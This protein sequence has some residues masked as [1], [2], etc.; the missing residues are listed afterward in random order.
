[1]ANFCINGTFLSEKRTG[2]YRFAEEIIKALDCQINE[3]NLILVVP[4]KTI[5]PFH[6]KKIKVVEFGIKKGILWEQTFFALYLFLH[7]A[8]AI[9][10]CNVTPLIAPRG[11]SVIHD[12]NY[13]VNPQ[14]FSHFYGKLS[15]K[16]HCIQYWIISHFAQHIFTVSEFSKSE[17]MRVYG[18]DE[19]KITVTPNGWQHMLSIKPSLQE[20]I[21]KFGLRSQCYYL[22]LSTIAPNK[23][24]K[25]VLNAAKNNPNEIFA[26][27]GSLNPAR[28]G[29]ELDI[30]GIQNVKFLG[31]ISDEDF[32]T[33]AKNCKAF[34]FP[35]FYEGFGLPPLE[36]MSLGTPVI[37]SDRCSLPEIFGNS[38]QY[39]N[40]NNPNINIDLLLQQTVSS[41]QLVLSNFSWSKSAAKIIQWVE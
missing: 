16:W 34:I 40:P 19:K 6:L 15:R 7:R 13:K 29:I 3:N 11:L 12:I 14:Y 36:V 26:I 32:V 10:L 33:L 18:V 1:M 35:S 20:S 25:W 2:I 22:S 24:L 23:N 30:K 8:K 5:I 9:N 21:K 27:A 41:N 28:F 4:R 37:V 38:A 39:I 17:I 31:Y